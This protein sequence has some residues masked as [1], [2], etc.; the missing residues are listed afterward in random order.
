MRKTPGAAASILVAA[1][2]C[3]A[4]S[5]GGLV[6]G[7]RTE[8]T[9][10]TP[11]V[12]GPPAKASGARRSMAPGRRGGVFRR[13]DIQELDTLNIVTTRSRSAYNV[14]KLV[15]EGLLSVNPLTGEIQGGI[16]KEYTVIN[17]GF[18]LLL[19]LNEGVKFSD[20]APCTADDVVFSFEEI[21][22]NPDVDSRK[23]DALKIRDKLV[24]VRK[25]DELTVRFDLPVP[26]RPFLHVLANM[27]ILPRHVLEPLIAKNGIEHFNRE[28]GS[29][30][31]DLGSLVGTGPYKLKEL[32]KGEYLKLSRNTHYTRR[33]GSLHLDKMPYID[34]IVELLD[35][36]DETK[37]LKFQ[38]GELDFYDI[39]D[40]DI[41]SGDF[42]NLLN[43]RKEGK[44][45]I[46]NGGETL[47]SNHFLVFNQNP[48]A[49]QKDKL[50]VFRSPAFRRAVSLLVDRQAI[51]EAT[52]RGYAYLNPSPERSVSP[53]YRNQEP[54]KYDRQGAKNLLSEVPLRDG[55]G[56][57][58]L[59][60]PSGAP[61]R[62]TVASNG[63]NPFRVK[64]GEII[65][66]SLR[67]AGLD[68]S[69]QSLAYDLVVTKLLETFEW[70]AVIIGVEGSVEPNEGSWIWESRG[71]LH[72]WAPYGEKPLTEWEA[73][74]DELFQ[75]GRTTW[76]FD[77]AGAYYGE[78][79][80]IVARELP[81][82][83]ILV[84]AE[85]YGVRSGFRNVQ[86]H[87]ATYNA[88]GL[89]P[90]VWKQR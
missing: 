46:Y 52:Y 71:Q 16:A 41:A 5:A 66:G 70:D 37:I 19:R 69:F 75:L 6:S 43:N 59:E 79:Q 33:E 13:A 73:R 9:A 49:V 25:I 36:D 83:G 53:F 23:T 31:G 51:S 80:D 89:M 27:E 74:V 50:A 26:Y 24:E 85:L 64:M 57:G 17:D 88:L 78:Y 63:D 47:R 21:Y 3:A 29:L 34:E 11:Q 45:E 86:P 30:D 87:S 20:G 62:F 48:V 72:L 38:V 42:D 22:L 14:L 2:V 76:G 4:L 77:K 61:F 58:L 40:T 28:W 7:C 65:T 81:V 55:N 15:F 84:P 8:R 12:K 35:L 54:L 67:S 56:D 1:F 10:A 68:A 39:K 60:L 44:Y 18:S 32:K 82:I 90:F